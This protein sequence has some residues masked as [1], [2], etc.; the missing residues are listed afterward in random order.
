MIGVIEWLVK[1]PVLDLRGRLG[2]APILHTYGSMADKLEGELRSGKKSIAVQKLR[3]W[4]VNEN[5]R[6]ELF[7]D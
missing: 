1:K 5:L 2:H 3:Q 4:E 7:N 6:R